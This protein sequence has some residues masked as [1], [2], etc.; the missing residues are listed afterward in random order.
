MGL[1]DRRENK[2]RERSQFGAGGSAAT[3]QLRARLVSFGDDYWIENQ[4]GDRVLRVDGK[5][6]RVRK[7]AR[8]RGHPGE[9]ACAASRP[10]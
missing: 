5:V 9:A 8:H 1:R 6:L 7:T 10:G 4:D 3:Y 2:R